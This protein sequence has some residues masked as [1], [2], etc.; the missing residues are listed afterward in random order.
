M[1]RRN[2]Q[3]LQVV[4][5]K[6]LVQPDFGYLQWMK[7]N[8]SPAMADKSVSLSTVMEKFLDEAEQSLQEHMKAY[9]QMV[10]QA[11]EDKINELVESLPADSRAEMN[12]NA[13]DTA[14]AKIQSSG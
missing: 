9:Y 12:H 8:A 6:N 14:L 2:Y 11:A 1:R 13:Y 3:S 7:E 5:D 10:A 4:T